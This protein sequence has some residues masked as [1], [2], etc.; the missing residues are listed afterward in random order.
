MKIK[1]IFSKNILL[2]SSLSFLILFGGA[3]KLFAVGL[4]PPPGGYTPGTE[5]DPDCVPG[6]LDC[7]VTAGTVAGGLDTEVQYNDGG[8]LGADANFVWN[9]T[10]HFLRAGL[11]TNIQIGK[12]AGLFTTT[13]IE[14]IAIGNDALAANV[15]GNYNV[16]IGFRALVND[17]STGNVAFG[18]WALENNTIGGNNQA[19]GDFALQNNTI[20]ADNN[21]F[22]ESAVANNQVGNFNT[23]MGNYA[24]TNVL[25]SYNTAVGASSLFTVSTGSNNVAIGY[26]AGYWETGSNKLFIDNNPRG[27]EVLGRAGSLLYGVFNTVPQLQTLAVNGMLGI[28]TTPSSTFEVIQGTT[29]PGTVTITGGPFMSTCTGINTQFKNTFKVGDNITITNTGQTKAISSITSDTVM[30][31]DGATA[32]VGS[33]YTLSNAGTRFIVKGNGNVGIGQASSD[34]KLQVYGSEENYIAMFENDGGSDTNQGLLIQAGLSDSSA[35]GPSTLIE[36]NDG[37]SSEIGSITFGSSA[38][39]YNTTS[40]RRLKEN[41]VDTSLSLDDLNRIQIHDFTWKADNAHK[42]SHGV[43]AQELY[44]VYP[45]AVTKPVDENKDYW[46][47]DYSKLSPLIIK[48]IQDLNLKVENLENINVPLINN[49]IMAKEFCVSETECLNEQELRT[50]IQEFKNSHQIITPDPA[51]TPTCSDG[52]QNQDETGIDTG[53][54]CGDSVPI[55]DPVPDPTPT[56]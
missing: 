51:P 40:D 11:L 23:A 30:T 32:T 22:G 46:M 7:I 55:P 48:S 27:S 2:I 54:V 25:T 21:G 5:L 49:R 36:F 15:T 37:S 17:T 24:L 35:L 4:P 28:G 41:I 45:G 29:G 10:S 6:S 18:P 42:I 12:N 33:A 38:T 19:F 26:G 39:S 44:E 47:V 14:N 3:L 20:G 52:I 1:N 50:F 56:E 13:G 43:I 34:Y 9:K 8:L 16:A 53:G 31:I